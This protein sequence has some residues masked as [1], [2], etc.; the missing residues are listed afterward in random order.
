[1]EYKTRRILK[2]TLLYVGIA[3]SSVILLAVILFI[4]VYSGMFGPLPGKAELSAINNEEASLVYSSD[5]IVIGKYFAENRTNIRWDEIPV[6]LK[7]ALIATE[8]KRF[9]TH[10]GS[11]IQSYIRVFFKS[12]LLRKNSGGGGSTLTQQLVKNLYGRSDFGLLSLPVNKIREIIIAGRI[13]EI[14]T[15]EQLLLLYFNSVPF[16]KDVYGVE[17]ASHRYFNKR[18]AQLRVE[19]S[20]VLVGLLKANTYFNPLLNPKNSLARRNIVLR[21]MATQHYLSAQEA[22]R[23]QKL[24][25]GLNPEYVSVKAPA[26]YFVYQVRK[27]TLELLEGVKKDTGKDYDLEKDGLKIYTTLNMKVQ[28]M[29]LEAVKNHLA[30][31]QKMLDRELGNNFKKQWYRK[32]KRNSSSYNQDMHKRNIEVFDWQ[33][34]QTRHISR[35]DSIWHYYKMLNAAVLI[36]NPKNGAVI[37]WIGGNQ[38][39]TLPFDMVLSHRQIASA[40]KPFLYA[41]ALEEGFSPCSYLENEEKKYPGYEDWEPQNANNI[42]TPN[43]TVAFWYALVNSMNLPTIDLYFKV[44]RD[45]LMNTCDKL[46]FPEFS[47]DAPSIALGTLDLSLFEVVRAYSAIAN[48]GRMNELVMIDKITDAGGRT[49]YQRESSEPKEIFSAETSATI[50]A[51]LK[52]AINQGTGSRIRNQYGIGSELAGKTG[53]AQNYSDAWFFAYTPDLV[54]GTW[55][56]ASTPDVHFFSGAGS[57]ASLAL[58]VVAKVLGGIERDAALKRRFLTPFVLP[59]ELNSFLDCEPYR[60]TGIKG[61]FN[62]LFGGDDKQDAKDSVKTGKNK[63]EKKSFFERLFKRD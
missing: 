55:V 9:F 52:E 10:K 23:L 16:G 22:A 12:I 33:G 19:E 4:L 58:P 36:T 24:P 11:D 15:K 14:Y 44:G 2:K 63:R 32:Q 37:S 29:A 56:G 45:K 51:I 20:A 35:T 3:I 26:G 49:L 18:T 38:F 39:T 47:G 46:N 5:S 50:T 8:D 28:E 53:T 13:E 48:Q 27:K 62:R 43:S 6:N 17:A 1:M 54:L 42:S 25:L 7:N 31:M 59:D 21:L 30:V 57:G 61:F 41:T 40:F 34:M 60:Q